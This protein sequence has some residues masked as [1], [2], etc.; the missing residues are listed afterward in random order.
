MLWRTYQ[1]AAQE[2]IY[3]EV[4]RRILSDACRRV[5]MTAGDGTTLTSVIVGAMVSSGIG[6]M[7]MEYFV[8]DVIEAIRGMRSDVGGKL[9]DVCM[10]A[11]NF[12]DRVSDICVDVL[13]K[14]GEYGVVSIEEVSGVYLGS[15]VVN[16]YVWGRGLVSPEFMRG[17]RKL[18]LDRPVVVI[19]NN[20]I[21]DT[22]RVP[23]EL[24]LSKRLR[25]ATDP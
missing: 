10:V 19:V 25:P 14:L 15:E 11:S 17:S 21:K 2:R 24:S 1:K 18:V 20:E 16:G 9:R 23:L 22:S 13:S 3:Q 6:V 12:D 5:V 7:D 4:G 8:R